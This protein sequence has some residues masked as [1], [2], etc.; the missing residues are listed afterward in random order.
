MLHAIIMAGGAGTRFWPASTKE[1]PKQLLDLAS[2]RTMIQE[3]V[4][5]L[6]DL[7][8]AE[9]TMIV[10]NR[11]L[12]TSIREQLPDLPADSVVG[13]PCKRDTAPCVGL[14]AILVAHQDPDAVMIVMPADHVIRPEAKFRSAVEYAASLLEEDPTRIVTFGIR[15]TYPA[16]SYGYIERGEVLPGSDRLLTFQIKD[17]HEKPSVEVAQEYL[18]RG[19]FYWNAGI[20]VWRAQ[21]I[22]DALKKFEPEMHDRLMTIAGSIGTP[23]YAKTLEQEFSAIE[24]KSI[25]Y[26]VMEHYENRLIVEASFEWDDVG[27]WSSLARLNEPDEEGNIVIGRHVGYHTVNSIIRGHGE[28]LVAT[29]GMKNCII[30]H[31]PQATLV[32]NREDEESIRQ[33]VSLIEQRGWSHYL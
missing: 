11:R 16:A 30:V 13:E 3:T 19:G 6:G 24:G 26:A 29:L 31:T 9:R 4:D 14:A 23:E 32:A 10:T 20:F 22:L 5:R 2:S 25:D 28:H 27:N 8:P 17:F 1:I 33:L 15:P 12:E 21:T 18:D 7:A